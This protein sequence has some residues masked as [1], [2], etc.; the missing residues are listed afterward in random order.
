MSLDRDFPN[1][2]FNNIDAFH[3]MGCII[4]KEIPEVAP[5]MRVELIKPPGMNGTLHKTYGDYE[6][7]NLPISN[8]SI[9]YENLEDVKRW[10][11]GSGR[12][13]THNDKD[14]YLQ[15]R[16]RH[17]APLE[18]EN[19]IGVFY[20][21]NLVFECQPLKRKVNEQPVSLKIG[22]TEIHNPGTEISCPYFEIISKGGS[23]EIIIESETFTL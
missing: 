5:N 10:L 2:I 18:F 16:A 4:E 14:K 9:P 19:E 17:S 23:I 22:E 1:F 3:D 12:L 11:R 6:S 20:N 7:F 21:F 15:A 8:I 13:I